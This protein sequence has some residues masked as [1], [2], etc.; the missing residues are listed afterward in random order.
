[1]RGGVRNTLNNTLIF[2]NWN[3]GSNSSVAFS[4]FSFN[5]STVSSFE[6]TIVDPSSKLNIDYVHMNLE[7]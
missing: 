1:M 3:A 6:L 5:A 2:K 7:T 4:V